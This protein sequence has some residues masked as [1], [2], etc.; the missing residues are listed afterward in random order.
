MDKDVDYFYEHVSKITFWKR[1]FNEELKKNNKQVSVFLLVF[2]IG[3]FSYYCVNFFLFRI[4][5][6]GI[7][8][9]LN[10]LIIN[11]IFGCYLPVETKI[12]IGLEIGHPLGIVINARSKIGFNCRIEHQVTVGQNGSFV[13]IIGNSVY[14]GAGA[15]IIGKAEICDNSKIG[16]NAVVNK[17]FNSSGLIVGIP[18]K[19]KRS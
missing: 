3:N 14:I 2:R 11:W 8:K 9:L 4:I 18:A 13:P 15:K 16:A 7:S 6:L 1:F 5:L 17:K 19:L 12:G 10:V